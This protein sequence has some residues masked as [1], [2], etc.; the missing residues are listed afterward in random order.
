MLSRVPTFQVKDFKDTSHSGMLLHTYH[1][2]LSEEY[3]DNLFF[4]R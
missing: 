2:D 1:I 3:G 4:I